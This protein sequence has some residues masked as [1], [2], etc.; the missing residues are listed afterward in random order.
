MKYYI[1][2]NSA[3]WTVNARTLNEAKRMADGW[4]RKENYAA[5]GLCI[6]D[7][8]DHMI[9][10]RGCGDTEDIPV[11]GMKDTDP[12]MFKQDHYYLHDWK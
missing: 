6:T 11:F 2:F 1:R 10:S 8:N 4:A 3:L 7:G 9:A 12:I 5:T